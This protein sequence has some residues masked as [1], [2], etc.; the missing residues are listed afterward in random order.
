MILVGVGVLGAVAA[1]VLATQV[2]QNTDS[3]ERAIGDVVTMP[4]HATGQMDGTKLVLRE[5]LTLDD[6]FDRAIVAMFGPLTSSEDTDQMR[7]PEGWQWDRS[8]AETKFVRTRTVSPDRGLP[9]GN[10]LTIAL[11]LGVLPVR[12]SAVSLGV[13]DGS[14]IVLTTP[15]ITR[16]TP[17]AAPTTDVRPEGSQV[18]TITVGHDTAGVTVVAL[19]ESFRNAAGLGLYRAAQW[20]GLPWIIGIMVALFGSVLWDRLLRR[21]APQTTID[22]TAVDGR[23]EDRCGYEASRWYMMCSPTG[24]AGGGRTLPAPS[25]G[26][27]I[28]ATCHSRDRVG[29]RLHDGVELHAVIAGRARPLDGVFTERRPVPW[30]WRR[31]IDHET[32]GGDVGSPARRWAPS[33]LS[34]APPQSSS[35]TTTWPGGDP[36]TVDGRFRW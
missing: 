20:W 4:Y 29:I 6:D 31:G 24:R 7:E 2:L 8:G 34:R 13:R 23:T 22:H 11:D 10:R 18:T 36:S 14:Q 1:T 32:R 15:Q 17:P 30:P 33:S 26:S 12:G 21:L 9:L 27:R 19:I 16:A 28:R 35:A 3:S 25:S 5:E